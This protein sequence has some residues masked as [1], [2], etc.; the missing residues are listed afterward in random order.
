MS[1]YFLKDKALE[2]Y[3]LQKSKLLTPFGDQAQIKNFEANLQPEYSSGRK[4]MLLASTGEF[5]TRMCK[6]LGYLPERA[7][8]WIAVG[9]SGAIL[10]ARFLRDR[11]SIPNHQYQRTSDTCTTLFRR[12]RPL[13][14]NY[15]HQKKFT[16]LSM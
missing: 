7:W 12:S 13:S 4:T 10:A 11:A 14:K 1:Q 9:C 6:I 5:T 8:Y 16:P 3:D 15:P 2:R